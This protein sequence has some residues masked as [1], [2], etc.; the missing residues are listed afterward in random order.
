M[1]I[2]MDKALVRTNTKSKTVIESTR[3][4][5]DTLDY[6]IKHGAKGSEKYL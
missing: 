1:H 3:K 5:K 4:Q 2:S 6:A